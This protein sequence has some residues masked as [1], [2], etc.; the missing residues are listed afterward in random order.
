MLSI[1]ALVHLLAE[2]YGWSIEYV[3]NLTRRQ[4]RLLTEGQL[5]ILD[6]Q[7]KYKDKNYGVNNTANNDVKN[8]KENKTSNDSFYGLFALPGVKMTPKA[9]KKFL[10]N[11]KMKETKNAT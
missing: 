8:K 3:M 6:I 1:H 4:I 10:E 7:E 9:K 11:K 2:K 5:E